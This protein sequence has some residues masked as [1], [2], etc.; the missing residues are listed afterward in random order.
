M[1]RAEL[2]KIHQFRQLIDAEDSVR[3]TIGLFGQPGA[4]KSSLINALIGQDRAEV[5]VRNDTTTG[6]EEYEWNGLTLVDLPGYDTAR[7]PAEQY[8]S[9]FKVWDFDL[10]I[11]VFDGKFHVADTRL[12]HEITH[13]GKLSLFVRTKHD[14]LFQNGRSIAD[15]EGDVIANVKAQIGSDQDVYF[16]SS[17]NRTGFARLEEAIQKHLEPAKRDRWIR[18]AKAYSEAFLAEKKALCERRVT[19]TAAAAMASGVTGTLIPVPG[20]NLAIDI[21]LLVQLFEFIRQTYGIPNSKSLLE[22]ATPVL[23]PAIN[24]IVRYATTEGILALLA[25]FAG[26]QLAQNLSKFV[27]IVGS[28]IAGAAGF[29]IAHQAGHSFVHDCHQVAESLLQQNL[30]KK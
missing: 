21:P 22:M 19:F 27:P 23:S 5:S 4:G 7:F 16:T 2:E 25:S 10:L 12:F 3:V 24:N 15:L 29:G 14:A 26:K 11:C 17:R 30:L 13:Q 6:R 28:V 1:N 18:A 9:Q 20:A 8:I